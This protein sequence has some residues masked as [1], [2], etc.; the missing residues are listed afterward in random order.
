MGRVQKFLVTEPAERALALVGLEH[1]LAKPSLV[2]SPADRRGGVTSARDVGIFVELIDRVG[3]PQTD[4]GGIIDGHG[5]REP[6]RLVAH[7]EDRPCSQVA[8]GDD[9]VEIG[10]RK[11]A[12]HGK[13]QTPVIGVLRVGA[14]VSIPK[15][16]V[17]AEG[18]I[19]RPRWRRGD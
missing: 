18:V 10:K 11:A 14:A 3:R 9:S 5:E 17:R 4:V 19:V 12:I 6:A 8:S 15:Q 13:T 1:P 7:D 16:P 2:E